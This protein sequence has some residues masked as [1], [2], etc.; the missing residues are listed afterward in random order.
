MS[1]ARPAPLRTP[2]RS[3]DRR[4]PPLAAALLLLGAAPAT[5]EPFVRRAAVDPARL[6]ACAFAT[7]DR[8]HPGAVRMSDPRAAAI[9]ITARDTGLFGPA[10]A[11]W[12]DMDIRRAGRGAEVII[13]TEPAFLGED[14]SPQRAWRTIDGCLP[15]GP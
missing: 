6:A 14:R 15:A 2:T 5:A 7:L 8:A 13:R 9:R 10:P 1:P 11:P 4:T 3:L 12:L